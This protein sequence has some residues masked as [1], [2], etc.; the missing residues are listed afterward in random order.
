MIQDIDD[1]KSKI[2]SLFA[3][4]FKE[5]D[6]QFVKVYSGHDT[7]IAAI[8]YFPFISAVI[9]LLRK[10]NSE[11]VSFH[12]RQALVLLVVSAFGLL[13]LPVAAKLIV[14]IAVFALLVYGG[15]IAVNGK[16]WYLP[17]VTELANTMEL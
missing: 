11:F 5:N 16:K 4:T 6:K 14:F 1:L 15:Y 9:L 7:Y 8:S 12:A 13:I 3:H 17:L 10:E 2:N